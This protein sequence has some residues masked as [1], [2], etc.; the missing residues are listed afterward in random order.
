MQSIVNRAKEAAIISRPD[1]KYASFN[2]RLIAST[3]DLCLIMFLFIPLIGPVQYLIFGDLNFADVLTR[4]KEENNG[5]EIDLGTFWRIMVSSGLLLKCTLMNLISF[6]L[7]FFIL[8]YS[9][10]KY[11]TTPGKWLLGCRIVDAN[12]YD[13]PAKTQYLLRFLGY[14]IATL[15]IYIGFLTIM[16]DKRK[17]GWHDKIAKTVVIVEGHDF[18]WFFRLKDNFKSLLSKVA[19]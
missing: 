7:F 4:L 12:T 5:K 17:Q 6:F 10:V 14:I 15:P 18:S 19:K 1:I 9:W 11:D 16:W 13:S 8:V 2:R 3:V